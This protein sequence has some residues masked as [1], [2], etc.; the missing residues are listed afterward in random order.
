MPKN[1]QKF[2]ETSPPRPPPSSKFWPLSSSLAECLNF[3]RH[4]CSLQVLYQFV[5]GGEFLEIVGQVILYESL[6]HLYLEFW[7]H[8]LMNLSHTS[9]K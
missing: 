2:L 6:K 5:F 8:P 4:N 1:A 7:I 3:T 9:A